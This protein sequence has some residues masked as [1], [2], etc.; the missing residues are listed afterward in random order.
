VA[1]SGIDFEVGRERRGFALVAAGRAVVFQNSFTEENEGNK[2]L[3]VFLSSK[4]KA[5]LAWKFGPSR[6]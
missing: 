5:E 6:H 1:K 4:S 2:E 3:L